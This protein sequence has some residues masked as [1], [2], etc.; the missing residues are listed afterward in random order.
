[1][2]QN[3]ETKANCLEC[4]TE[5]EYG[6]TDRKF[7][8]PTCKNRYNNRKY[9]D[10]RSLHTRIRGILEKNYTILDKLIKLDISSMDM[11]DIVQWGFN[12]EYSTGHRKVRGHNEYRCYEIKYLISSSRIFNIERSKVGR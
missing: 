6:R 12:P 3:E 7:C 4:G 5:L 11:G 1:M 8:C 10:I 2:K 9:Y